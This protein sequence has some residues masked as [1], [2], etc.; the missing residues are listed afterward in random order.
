MQCSFYLLIYCSTFLHKPQRSYYFF[1]LVKLSLVLHQINICWLNMQK[2]FTFGQWL[3][4][5]KVLLM[6]THF[7]L[8]KLY[9][10]LFQNSQSSFFILHKTEMCRVRTVCFNT[11]RLYDFLSCTK[12]HA[13]FVLWYKIYMF[14]VFILSFEIILMGYYLQKYIFSEKKSWQNTV[15]S[16]SVSLYS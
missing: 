3:F 7:S 8:S 9:F 11:Q 16:V 2:Q 13:I 10:T 14:G 5:F 6:N 15:I 1:S 12:Y 4:L